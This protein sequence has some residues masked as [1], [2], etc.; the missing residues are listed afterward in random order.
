MSEPRISK[1]RM[2]RAMLRF[3]EPSLGTPGFRLPRTKKHT[4]GWSGWTPAELDELY[5]EMVSEAWI[6]KYL[7]PEQP[8]PPSA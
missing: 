4:Q 8:G 3:Y 5:L 2:L 1:E 6:Q 7:E